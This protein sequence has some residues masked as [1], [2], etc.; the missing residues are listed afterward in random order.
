MN[1]AT[2]EPPAPA[3]PE[4]ATCSPLTDLGVPRTSVT[5]LFPALKVADLTGTDTV[6]FLLTFCVTW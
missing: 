5:E 1:V 2:G 4:T 3:S 6:F